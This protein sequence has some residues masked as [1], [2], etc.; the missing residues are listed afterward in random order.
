MPQFGDSSSLRLRSA[1]RG[2][3]RWRVP[4]IYRNPR[5][6]RAVS[7]YLE[8]DPQ[9]L[10]VGANPATA[11]V[12]VTYVPGARIDVFQLLGEALGLVR[13]RPRAAAASRPPTTVADGQT[14]GSSR[15]PTPSSTQEAPVARLLER[16]EVDRRSFRRATATA[17][18][19]A[20]GAFAPN[21]ALAA[22]TNAARDEGN[23]LLSRL[24]I[25]SVN[26]Q[27]V[28]L[29][30]TVVA[31]FGLD[32]SLE[33]INKGRWL[34]FAAELE[35]RVKLM[36]FDHIQRLDLSYIDAQSTGQLLSIIVEDAAALRRYYEEGYTD[37]VK[38]LTAV[39]LSNVLLFSVSPALGLLANVSLP[40][41][42]A[43]SRY[44]KPRTASVY[45]EAASAQAEFS[46]ALTDNLSGIA[47]IKSFTNEEIEVE[48]LRELNGELIEANRRAFEARYSHSGTMRGL[49]YVSWAT[50][51]T[52]ASYLL[53]VGKISRPL[54]SLVL[55]VIPQLIA[56]MF[57]I[58]E[59]TNLHRRANA[60]AERILGIL[61]I[62]TEVI[63]G[64]EELLE[65][66]Q[67]HVRFEQV[68]FAYPNN[69]PVLDGFDLDIEPGITAIVG[70]SGSGKSTVAKLLMRFYDV[71]EGRVTLDS[72]DIREPTLRSLR[73]QIGYVGQEP[74]LFPGTLED[75]IRFG[76]PSASL[77]DIRRA[78]EIA[79]ISEF[80]ESLP[81]GYQTRIGERGARLSGGQR[82]RV[83]IA[84]ALLKDPPIL[85][86]DEA[87]AAVDN[88]TEAALQR[89]IA[90]I[91][92]GRTI[93]M[94]AHRLDSIRNAD[95]IVV[96][97]RGR[98]QE[99]GTHE[100]LLAHKGLYASLWRVQASKGSEAKTADRAK[101]AQK[102]EAPRMVA[103][104][105]GW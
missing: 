31:G 55:Y 27:L 88:K 65:R 102:V 17:V 99:S 12:L 89:S 52:Q 79:E 72:R 78:A 1:T 93:I 20:A 49:F 18:L 32:L 64:G 28:L 77:D 26:K 25:E 58:D 39:A 24:G 2:R 46:K 11:G 104:R 43:A 74:Y 16:I 19:A 38:K 103:R 51:V 61:E 22:V 68:R 44:F 30:S 92:E 60:A 87:T 36:A 8:H 69:E 34:E 15:A 66:S 71:D 63:D 57:G 90:R 42:Y 6:A 67:G 80:I 86:L 97:E 29:G 59:T 73:A 4:Q 50:T 23:P 10:S 70:S 91:A 81:E 37:I 41:I 75:N 48:R 94:I 47:T 9:V 82:Q 83:C 101:P 56:S 7:E 95:R 14:G 53:T 3:E 13:P 100:Q 96:I 85:V 45:R 105:T 33:Y 5:R 84:R 54:Y 62:E 98:I 40:L 35:D 76:R 21:L